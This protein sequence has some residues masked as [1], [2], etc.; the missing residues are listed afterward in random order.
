MKPVCADFNP[1]NVTEHK[2]REVLKQLYEACDNELFFV[3]RVKGKNARSLRG[4]FFFCFPT[5][6][7][8]FPRKKLFIT[9]VPAIYKQIHMFTIIQELAYFNSALEWMYQNYGSI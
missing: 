1:T 4:I 8:V 9:V 5:Q 2:E 7:I 6:Y 3:F